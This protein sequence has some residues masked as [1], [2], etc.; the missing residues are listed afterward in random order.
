MVVVLS[1]NSEKEVIMIVTI[2]RKVFA[3]K[4]KSNKLPMNFYAMPIDTT[5]DLPDLVVTEVRK[6]LEDGYKA[7]GNANFDL[8]KF[9]TPKP[10][11]V[12]GY[13][14]K[15]SNLR[16]FKD[17]VANKVYAP[18]RFLDIVKSGKRVAI[19]TYHAQPVG[20][21]KRELVI[22]IRKPGEK[23]NMGSWDRD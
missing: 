3:K 10:K 18:G 16:K 5:V 13:T 12:A 4:T 7:F 20:R 6:M 9:E 22:K 17:K 21:N 14:I 23:F 11:K 19:A 8:D 1:E 15:V 2:L